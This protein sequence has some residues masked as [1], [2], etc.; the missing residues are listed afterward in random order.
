MRGFALVGLFLILGGLAALAWPAITYT[1]TERVVDIGPLHVT[2]DDHQRIP[3][4]PLVGGIAV[5][6]GVVIMVTGGRR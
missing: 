3:L 5:A 4:P 6:A 2:K 1:K